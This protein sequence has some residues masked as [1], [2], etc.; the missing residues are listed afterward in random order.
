MM[1]TGMAIKWIRCLDRY[2]DGGGEAGAKTSSRR[3][4]VMEIQAMLCTGLVT[5]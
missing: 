5:W 4:R 1:A 2:R 3:A